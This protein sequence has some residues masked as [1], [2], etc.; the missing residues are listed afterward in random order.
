MK[1]GE[2]WLVE[3]NPN[4]PEGEPARRR[5]ALVVSSERMNRTRSPAVIVIPLT[6]RRRDLAMRVEVEASGLDEVSYAITEQITVTAKS[7]LIHR[8]A[9]AGAQTMRAVDDEL[10]SVLAL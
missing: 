10:R 8:L 1:R 2:I 5:P 6:T 7:R 9:E 3:H 4:A